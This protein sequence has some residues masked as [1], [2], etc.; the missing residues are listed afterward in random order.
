MRGWLTGADGVLLVAAIALIGWLYVSVWGP[1]SMPLE[2]E[3]WSR[4]QRVE[5]LPLAEDRILDIRGAMGT[6]RIEIKDGQARFV[7]SP[8]TN[9][10]CILHGWQRHAGETT[11]CVPNR[12]SLRILGRDA[13][14]DAINF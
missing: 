9:K 10:L 7:A 14:Y 6:S 11:A 5:Q 4:G 12:V 8:C 2:I 13:R 3:I 1:S